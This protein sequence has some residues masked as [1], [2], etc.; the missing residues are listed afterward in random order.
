MKLIQAVKAVTLNEI[1][2]KSPKGELNTIDWAKIVRDLVVGCSGTSLVFIIQYLSNVD[3]SKL[4]A[5]APAALPF[6]I[7]ILQAIQKKLAA[8][9]DSTNEGK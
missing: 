3:F 9:M 5:W 2:S 8:P 4:G 7:M 1:P 6:V